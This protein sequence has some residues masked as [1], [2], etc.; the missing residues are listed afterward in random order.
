MLVETVTAVFLLQL[1]KHRETATSPR[2]VSCNGRADLPWHI[3]SS[4]VPLPQLLVCRLRP[5]AHNTVNTSKER[6]RVQRLPRGAASRH[7]GGR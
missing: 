4:D 6:G 7:A 3:V 5:P 2:K 1:R